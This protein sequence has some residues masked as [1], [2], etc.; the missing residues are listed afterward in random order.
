M[1]FQLI[2]LS[3]LLQV[4][5]RRLNLLVNLLLFL[6]PLDIFQVKPRFVLVNASGRG[7]GPW[8]HVLALLELGLQDTH[9]LIKCFC[10]FFHR[11]PVLVRALYFAHECL[12]HLAFLLC[13][14]EACRVRKRCIR[15]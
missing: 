9:F 8:I 7:D 14:V 4:A 2:K 3:E 10:N 1:E 15:A 5:D 13:R 6:V 12:L 11:L